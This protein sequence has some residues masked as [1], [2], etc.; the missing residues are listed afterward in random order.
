MP[1]IVDHQARRA[2]I[3]EALWRVVAREGMAGTSVR[4]VAAEAGASV[5]AMRHY[6]ASQDE[7]LCFAVTSMSERVQDRVRHRL[8][9]LGRPPYSTS[10][11]VAILQE[12]VPLDALRRA[13]FEAWLELVMRARTDAGLRDAALDAHRGVRLLCQHVVQAATGDG[14]TTAAA[15]RDAGVRRLTDELHG[16]VDGLSLH[17]ALYP[18]QTSPRRVEAVLRAH[19]EQLAQDG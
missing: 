14:R 8:G 19:V 10:D 1:K 12:V 4:S 17:L 13:E 5:G 18:D 15:G 7:L 2:Q 3:A 16:V 9:E 6:F 11:L